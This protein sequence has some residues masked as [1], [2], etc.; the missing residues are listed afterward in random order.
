MRYIENFLQ[1][2]D[3]NYGWV[4]VF[5]VF[6]LS[7]LAFGSLASISVF[8]KPVSLEFGWSRGQTSFAY[9]LASFASAAFGVIWG[10]L[11]DKYGTKW[12]GAI[13]AVCMSLTLFSLSGL[14]SIL[15]FYILYF[16]FGAFGCALLFSPLYANVGF[17]FRENPGLALGIAASGGAIGQ[18]FIPHI[19]GVLIESGGWEDAYIKLAII[20]IIIAF[21]VSLLI[22][23][24]PWRIT[25]RTED[26]PESRDFPLSEKEVVAWISF[27]VIFCCVCMS[28]PIMHLVPLLTDAG[29]T[30]EFATSV[31]MVLMICGAFGRIF[32]G[33]LGDRIG[34]LPGYILM[35]LGQT[36]FVVWFPH[37]SSP[38]G[39]Y[40]LAAFFGFT[41]SGVMSSILV[42][43]RMMVSAKYGARAMSLTSFFGWIGMGLGGF[44]G[45]YFF[46]I[47]GDYSWAFTF[48]G[49]M[50]VINLVIL[51]QFWLRIRNA[52][53]GLEVLES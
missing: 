32:G 37:L 34:A 53:K 11:A 43:T 2:R 4:M 24:S 8:L 6:V 30:L 27:A 38:T 15:Q 19:S 12:F 25:A 20:Y 23:E 17:W 51:S 35:S 29:F 47:Y 16:L 52:K 18:A 42:C 9:T 31:L 14:D 1:S 50:G 22:K 21:P 41:Y 49:I 44:L 7:G 36:V 48:A 3:I 33:I 5:V 13:G 26:E 39:I 28:V 45:G 40:L 10:Q 46:D